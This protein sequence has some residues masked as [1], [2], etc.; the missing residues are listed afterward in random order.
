M[1]AN[2]RA[3]LNLRLQALLKTDFLRSVA[4]LTGG[5]ASAQALPILVTPV[6]TRL[7]APE[8]FSVLGVF[9]AILGVSAVIVGG[10]YE[11]AIPIPREDETAANLLG[12]ALMCTALVTGVSAV[13][14][15]VFRDDIARLLHQEAL[16]GFL[17]LLPI[18]IGG[19]GAYVAF[20]SWAARK[21]A[22]SRIARTRLAQSVGGA[23][24]QLLLGWSGAGAVG[25]ICGQLV[26][27]FAGFLGLGRGA[28]KEDGPA[29]RKICRKG[30][31][32]AAAEF[33]RFPLFTAP[34][35]FANAAS[36][37]VPI[38]LIAGR[39]PGAEVGFLMLGM[40]LMQ[41][42]LALVGSSV[43]QVYY[44]QAVT[45]HREG[46]LSGFTADVIGRLA[47]AGVG[48]LIFFG[49]LAP[50]VS[51]PVLGAG[52]QRAGVLVSW[53]TPWFIFQFLS[54][55]V[56]QVLYVT[57]NQPLA[58]I[59][60]VCGLALRLSTVLAV[61]AIAGHRT[62]EGYAVSGFVFYLV[63]LLVVCRVAGV[64]AALLMRSCRHAVVS[65]CYWLGAGLVAASMLWAFA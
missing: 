65:T 14:V 37:Q 12:V 47:S 3:S 64:S 59:L 31:R 53:M 6:L 58:L 1:T 30:L 49:I 51:E 43:A 36:I 24:T 2:P 23:A 54:S 41:A 40:R 20:Q 27:S 21:R 48:P 32:T 16:A 28:L 55:P 29:L 18:G 56:S 57:S 5:T 11:T 50:W 33:K 26:A 17:W 25:L 60:Q 4:V 8:D 22:F 13:A 15:A 63:Y 45:E 44:T 9:A 34:E 62:A 38:L 39:V 61:A 19:T 35:A 52:W 46:R 10:Q 7:Y 42:P